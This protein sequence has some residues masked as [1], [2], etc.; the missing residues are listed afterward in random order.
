LRERPVAF[1]GRFQP[2]PVYDRTRLSPATPIAGPATI[3]EPGSSTIVPPGFH[4]GMDGFGNL[5]L[6]RR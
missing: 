1:A 6:E 2:T 4:A 5:V 3:E